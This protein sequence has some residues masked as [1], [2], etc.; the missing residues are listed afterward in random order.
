M[1]VRAGARAGGADA[2]ISV[3]TDG[4]VLGGFCA[5]RLDAADDAVKT[6]RCDG[7]T[8]RFGKR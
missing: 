7:S 2:A 6:A 4:T 1:L 8:D 5:K 3:F